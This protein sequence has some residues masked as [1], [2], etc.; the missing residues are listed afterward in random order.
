M[1]ASD[2]AALCG[3]RVLVTGGCGFIGSALVRRLTAEIGAQVLNIDK[4]TYAGSL[5][6]VAPVAHLPNYRFARMDVCDAPAVSAA[7]QEFRPDFVVHL[8]AESHVD[9]SI[10]G[11]AEFIRTN[12]LGAYT[13]L[14]A[15]HAYFRSL[16]GPQKDQFRFVH[17]STDEV[18]GAL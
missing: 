10:D 6:T 5:S 4:L 16:S 2:Q 15:A 18:F 17:I 8:A 3:R 7:I 12:V 1:R 14:E 13:V 11:P 9:R